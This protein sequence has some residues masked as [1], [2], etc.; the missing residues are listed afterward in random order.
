M[1]VACHATLTACKARGQAPTDAVMEKGLDGNICRCTGYRSI[2]DACK[3]RPPA[4]L[5][6]DR[7]KHCIGVSASCWW[8]GCTRGDSD[9][10]AA[11][12]WRLDWPCVALALQN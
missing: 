11:C 10:Y 4:C 8:Q 7:E 5:L 2:M 6:I 9:T 3:V 12:S 1:V